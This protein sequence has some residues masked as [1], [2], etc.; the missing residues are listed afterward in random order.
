MQRIYFSQ[1]LF[2]FVLFQPIF[3]VP[4]NIGGQQIFVQQSTQE[5][6]TEVTDT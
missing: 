1:S 3:Q 6:V 4:V 2:Y 5:D